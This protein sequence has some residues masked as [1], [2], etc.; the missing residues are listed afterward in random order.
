MVYIMWI[1]YKLNSKEKKIIFITSYKGNNRF[2]MSESTRYFH[3][4]FLQDI[5]EETIQ[6]VPNFIWIILESKIIKDG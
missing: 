4:V 3:T 5:W 1:K 2:P 6:K